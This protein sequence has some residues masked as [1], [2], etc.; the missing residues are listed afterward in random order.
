MPKQH[1]NYEQFKSKRQSKWY[2]SLR[3]QQAV[4][5]VDISH[6]QFINIRQ[7]RYYFPSHVYDETWTS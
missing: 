7:M 1:L 5:V 2:D 4:N 6:H 3:G